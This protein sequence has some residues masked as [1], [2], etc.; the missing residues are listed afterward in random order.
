MFSQCSEDFFFLFVYFERDFKDFFIPTHPFFSLCF[1]SFNYVP[2]ETNQQT[3]QKKFRSDSVSANRLLGQKSHKILVKKDP[4]RYPTLKI[5]LLL[6]AAAVVVYPLWHKINDPVTAEWN[7]AQSRIVL[8]LQSKG[9]F[10]ISV[11][12]TLQP[13]RKRLRRRDERN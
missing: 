2:R 3:N 12:V 10:F 4:H 1:D 11:T 13:R 5:L 6:L 9:F 7:N 8:E